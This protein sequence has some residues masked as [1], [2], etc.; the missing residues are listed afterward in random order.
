VFSA[1]QWVDGMFLAA[2]TFKSWQD[3]Y[4]LNVRVFCRG[5]ACSMSIVST[6]MQNLGT[7]EEGRIEQVPEAYNHLDF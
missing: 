3:N 5:L 4:A 6:V 2:K 1:H 7:Y